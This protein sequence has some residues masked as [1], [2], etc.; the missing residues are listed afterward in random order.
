MPAMFAEDRSFV[1]R[2]QSPQLSAALNSAAVPAVLMPSF[3][4]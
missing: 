1:K 3:R 4:E 2:E